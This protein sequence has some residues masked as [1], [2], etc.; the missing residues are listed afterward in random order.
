M[1]SGRLAMIDESKI[2]A[3]IAAEHAGLKAQF[4][5]AEGSVAPLLGAMEKIYRRSLASPIPPDTY[6]S[7]FP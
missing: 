4:D 3:E 1:R 6:P 7:R 2:L 5:R